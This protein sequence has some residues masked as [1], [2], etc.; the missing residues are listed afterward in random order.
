MG[1]TLAMVWAPPLPQRSLRDPAG[2]GPNNKHWVPGVSFLMGWV[3]AGKLSASPPPG[4]RPGGRRNQHGCRGGALPHLEFV[5]LRGTI[6]RYSESVQNM[7]NWLKA[8][9]RRS[10][11]LR[12]P[13]LGGLLCSVESESSGL[14]LGG[15]VG[16][17]WCYFFRY[18]CWR[19][20]VARVCPSE[21]EA[22]L[23]KQLPP[24][25]GLEIWQSP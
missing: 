13:F 20:R 8:R 16:G 1:A 14:I 18:C 7:A 23:P 17:F 21:V 11:N 6:L 25:R 24:L 2:V 22:W 4:L 12:G 3:L 9:Q 10:V 15:H 5:P 19:A